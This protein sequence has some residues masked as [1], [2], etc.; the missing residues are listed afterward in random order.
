MA[1][2]FAI[3]QIDR[4]NA[5][6]C[7]T[8]KGCLYGSRAGPL[9]GPARLTRSRRIIQFLIKTSACAFIWTSRDGPLGET[10][11]ERGEISLTGMKIS[12]YKRSQVGQPGCRDESSKIPP[13]AI[14]NNCQ[15]NVKRTKLSRQ[16]DE[17][18]S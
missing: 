13:Q 12:P 1:P 10:S 16:R 17:I 2:Y 14:F 18:F 7:E 5:V 15:N 11:L 4:S 3:L 6:G 9:T 8:S